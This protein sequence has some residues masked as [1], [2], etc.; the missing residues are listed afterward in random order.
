MLKT[1]KGKRPIYLGS[2]QT[3]QLLTIAIALMEEVSVLRD[4]LDTIERLA[5][6]KG[7]ILKDDIESYQPDPQADQEREQWRAAYLERVL[8]GLQ[9]Q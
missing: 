1:A 5:E 9:Q 8:R 3:D 2:Q 4:R 6:A 7:L